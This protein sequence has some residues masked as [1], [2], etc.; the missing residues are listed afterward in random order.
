MKNRNQSISLIGAFSINCGFKVASRWSHEIIDVCASLSRQ[1]KSW[2]LFPLFRIKNLQC[3]NPST[4]VSWKW[5]FAS[6][7]FL[8][9]AGEQYW[10]RGWCLLQ[11]NSVKG[12]SSHKDMSS[13]VP[14]IQKFQQTTFHRICCWYWKLKVATYWSGSG[15][16]VARFKEAHMG[17]ERTKRHVASQRKSK[18]QLRKAKQTRLL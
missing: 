9:L 13:H 1:W 18:F 12:K 3:P 6:F 17:F 15:N 16:L 2:D 8:D 5:Y 14:A 10:M 11:W 7:S 4:S